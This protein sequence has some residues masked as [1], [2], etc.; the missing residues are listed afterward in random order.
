M[1]CSFYVRKNKF[2]KSFMTYY[3]TNGASAKR[4]PFSFYVRKFRQKIMEWIII[5]NKMLTNQNKNFEWLTLWPCPKMDTLGKKWKNFYVRKNKCLKSNSHV[6]VRMH[7]VVYFSKILCQ[8]QKWTWFFMSKN[9]KWKK[10]CVNF[11]TFMHFSLYST[12]KYFI[13]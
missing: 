11:D 3:I 7:V 6:Q 5:D 4:Q 10:V 8:N 2:L 1:N 12:F 13:F 9:G